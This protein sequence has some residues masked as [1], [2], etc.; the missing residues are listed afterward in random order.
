MRA[1]SVD[2]KTGAVLDPD[3]DHGGVVGSF[4]WRRLH[5]IL[6]SSGE[7]RPGE[8]VLRYTVSTDGV[9]FYLDRTA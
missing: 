8:T 3:K 2:A 5:E 4:S 7:L 9:Q 6:R 1:F